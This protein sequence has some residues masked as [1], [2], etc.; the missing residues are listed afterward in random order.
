LL[1]LLSCLYM[2][3]ELGV[4]NWIGFG[5]W[6]AVGLIIYFSYGYRKSKLRQA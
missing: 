3:S 6:L 5:I 1:G 2:M 4:S